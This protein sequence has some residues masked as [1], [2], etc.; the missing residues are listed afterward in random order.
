MFNCLREGAALEISLLTS[1]DQIKGYYKCKI[2]LTF[3]PILMD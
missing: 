2:T 3:E 1:D